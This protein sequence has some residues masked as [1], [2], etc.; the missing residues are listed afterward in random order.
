MPLLLLCA[1]A[2]AGDATEAEVCPV[3]PR[4]VAEGAPRPGGGWWDRVEGDPDDPAEG[5]AVLDP[6]R[7]PVGV[8]TTFALRFEVGGAGIAP[9]GGFAVRD[10][11]FYGM[12]W[13]H[14]GAFTTDP[15]LCT[16]EWSVRGSKGDGLLT[17]RADSGADVTVWRETCDTDRHR[18]VMTE[19]I[20]LDPLP[21]GDVVVLT[22]GDVGPTDSAPEGDA[23]CAVYTPWR[24]YEQVTFP[25]A[26]RETPDQDYR[27]LP[28]SPAL[29]VEADADPVVALALLPSQ[30]VMG[31]PT[32]LRL[33][34][35]DRHGN[36]APGLAGPVRCRSRDSGG[37]GG[38][39]DVTHR[40][41]GRG[42]W[43]VFSVTFPYPG[44]RWLECDFPGGLAAVSNPIRIEAEAPATSVF[45]GDIHAH[46]GH[47]YTGPDGRWVDENVVYAR[48][49]MGLDF[50][51][52]VPKAKPLEIDEDGLWD[53]LQ[54]VCVDE[55][56]DAYVPFLGYEWMGDPQV[57]GHHN[58]YFDSCEAGL[59]DARDLAPLGESGSLFD[60]VRPL[61]R[62]AVI[63]PHAT[64]FTGH[65]WGVVS[66]QRTTA[67]VFSAWGDDLQDPTDPGA[68]QQGLLRGQVLGFV[69]A[70]DNH[71]GFMG[72]P[73]AAFNDRGGLAALV[74]PARTRADL[75][76]ALRGRSS[77]A[78]D[79]ARILLDFR[80]VDRFVATDVVT[81]PMGARYVGR[82]PMVRGTVHGTAPL[83]EAVL[84]SGRWPGGDMVDVARWELDGAWSAEL[85]FDATAGRLPF[86]ADAFYYLEAVQVDG[87][88]A[89]SSPIWIDRECGQA[90]DPLGIC[91]DDGDGRRDV[92]GDP[93]DGSPSVLPVHG[94]GA[95]PE[96][97]PGC[98]AAGSSTDLAPPAAWEALVLLGMAAGARR[99]SGARP[100][101]S[102]SCL[103]WPPEPVFG[104][105]TGRR[106]HGGRAHRPGSDRARARRSHGPPAGGSGGPL[107][108]RRAG[109]RADLRRS[110]APQR[111]PAPV[112]L[113]S[114]PGAPLRPRH[115]AQPL[116]AGGHGRRPVHARPELRVRAG[117]P[118]RRGGDRAR[119]ALPD[120][121]QRTP[122]HRPRALPRRDRGGP[123][124][125]ACGGPGPLPGSRLR[126]ALL[127]QHR[128][129]RREGQRL[130]RDLPRP[131]GRPPGCALA[132][133]PPRSPGAPGLNTE[134]RPGHLAPPG[135]FR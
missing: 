46:N 52:V 84:W 82:V 55:E 97:P 40:M 25:V 23:E 74:A 112:A 102:R 54:R 83:G 7:V 94:L 77:Y 104:S 10:P 95:R 107:P 109:R 13:S 78:T 72:N 50:G 135:P 59:A 113:R 89:W 5:S 65:N 93:D 34:G 14:Y 134:A 57:D 105:V 4:P 39:V 123:R 118:G 66:D 49:V 9:G 79:G 98:D 124:D 91:D 115:G 38:E 121:L 71:D 62:H 35:L 128:P 58:V 6:D 125:R 30:A 19:V 92:E 20:A 8:A 36:P 80:V 76:G 24:A 17:A 2:A 119:P 12:R 26:M 88:R 18:D 16:R 1:C 31:S 86:D 99:R 15:A 106:V 126:D 100:R 28:S 45:W 122:G 21:P 27:P 53:R 132:P 3:A 48:D 67:E 96:A 108:P 73:M 133:V 120:L 47:G 116:V 127:Q 90:A 117:A 68:V 11:V 56:T 129:H 63:L 130:L 85:S 22:F 110:A 51:A 43:G 29:R 101:M 131:P 70:S 37:G 42:G 41:D 111:V 61:G 69:A 64:C 75:F 44:V 33:V 103:L 114:A 60:L 87:G 81:I 32:D